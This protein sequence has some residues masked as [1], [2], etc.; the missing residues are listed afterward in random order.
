VLRSMGL[1]VS[2][3]PWSSATAARLLVMDDPGHRRA[4]L[5]SYLAVDPR[6]RA[7]ILGGHGAPVDS[8]QVIMLGEGSTPSGV[9]EVL[10]S[11]LGVSRAAVQ[12]VQA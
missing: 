12:E 4:E 1:G 8:D 3:E 6:R 7:V 10:G 2:F 5:S 11:I 9:A